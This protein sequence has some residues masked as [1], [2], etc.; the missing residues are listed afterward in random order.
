MQSLGQPQPITSTAQLYTE[1]PEETGT[2]HSQGSFSKFGPGTTFVG[3]Q[4]GFPLKCKFRDSTVDL[5]KHNLWGIG[6]GIPC[7][8]KMKEIKTPCVYG[9]K[10]INLV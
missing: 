4:L 8:P 9:S 2:I 7:E 6:P 10:E 3:G 1:S 5:L